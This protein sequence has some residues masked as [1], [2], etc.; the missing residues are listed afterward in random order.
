MEVTQLECMIFVTIVMG[1]CVCIWGWYSM[2]NA[3]IEALNWRRNAFKDVEVQ[4]RRRYDMLPMLVECV[5]GYALYESKTMEA[6]IKARNSGIRAKTE[7]QT[8]RAADR[9]DRSLRKL[10]ALSESYPKLRADKSFLSLQSTIALVEY[11]IACARSTYNEAARHYNNMVMSF[12]ERIVASH[13]GFKPDCTDII[14]P[15]E[16]G[17]LEK[18]P[19]IKFD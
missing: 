16:R 8:L 17:E 7:E 1:I 13:H 15:S 6:V 5:K 14:P 3:I 10:F 11:D 19:R 4:L 18:P 2:Y 9:T 12:P